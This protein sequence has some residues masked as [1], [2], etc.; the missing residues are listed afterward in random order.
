MA[1]PK[2]IAGLAKGLRVLRA[3]NA[4]NG[5]TVLQLSQET[6]LPRPTL[7]RILETL[8]REGYVT[9]SGP[10]DGFWLSHEVRTLSYGFLD[11]DWGAEVAAPVLMELG[12]EVV[13]PVDIA[14]LDG[15]SMLI[16]ETTYPTSPLAIDRDH[17]AP[18]GHPGYRAP[19]IG[20]SLGHA[21]LG[22]CPPAEREAIVE[23]LL[24]SDLEIQNK[25]K[26]RQSVKRL[27]AKTRR[28]GYGVRE[29]GLIPST[30]SIAVPVMRDTQVL[31]CIN[32][33]YMMSVMSLNK[34]VSRYLDIMRQAAEEIS[35]HYLDE[36]SS[37]T[38]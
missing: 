15:E 24:T 11:R 34:A 33:H 25:G 6:G 30:G 20:T 7:Y 4:D 29:G 28:Q 12:R 22:F 32:I 26:F 23:M 8:M 35:G 27:A 37:S 21:Y 17:G 3:L 13:W 5:S 31:A 36:K 10:R 38:I 18:R 19:L 16:R 2:Q 14:T 1:A 9:R